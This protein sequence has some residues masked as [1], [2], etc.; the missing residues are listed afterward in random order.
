[1][2]S[3]LPD[4]V[5]IDMKNPVSAFLMNAQDAPAQQL[6]PHQHTQRRR[7]QGIGKFAPRQMAPGIV[8]GSAQQQIPV[9]ISRANDQDHRVPLRLSNPVNPSP[10]QRLIQLPGDKAHHQS[11]HWH[12]PSL[13]PHETQ[14][15]GSDLLFSRSNGD[16]INA[17]HL[18][19]LTSGEHHQSPRSARSVHLLPL[20]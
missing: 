6:F 4:G 3:H 20:L 18:A 11:V 14:F 7:L 17:V 5:H 1:M 15:S 19:A 8:R 10:G 12:K 13:P 2:V 16:D 9:L